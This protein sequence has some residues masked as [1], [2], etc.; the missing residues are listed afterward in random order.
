MAAQ[1]KFYRRINLPYKENWCWST[2]YIS[3]LSYPWV[4]CSILPGYEKSEKTWNWII[5]NLSD[6]ML[7]NN[8]FFQSSTW[9][10]KIQKRAP[11]PTYRPYLVSPPIAT[12]RIDDATHDTRLNKIIFLGRRTCTYK[13]YVKWFQ[14]LEKQ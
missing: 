8:N 9:L 1:F 6:I 2:R 4:T 3:F 7:K 5:A 10:L 14:L 11:V 12:R 13:K